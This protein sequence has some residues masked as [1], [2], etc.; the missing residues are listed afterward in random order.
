MYTVKG[1]FKPIDNQA[2]VFYF[3]S[4]GPFNV[5]PGNQDPKSL[6]L[7]QI[8][9]L[10]W[11]QWKCWYKYQPLDHIR[12][13]FGEK[14]ALYYA[15]LGKD[16]WRLRHFKD[17]RII[18]NKKII[19]TEKDFYIALAKR[20]SVNWK[21]SSIGKSYKV[22]CSLYE[23]F[24]NDIDYMMKRLMTMTYIPPEIDNLNHLC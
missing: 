13:Y 20:I 11:G 17:S 9:Y 22:L 5:P 23:G 19:P 10:Y 2:N 14:I 16:E 21:S 7:R 1:W 24:M 15:W 8:L 6:N 4:Q 18:F 12:Q 3:S